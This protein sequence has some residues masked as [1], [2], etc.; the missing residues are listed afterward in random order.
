MAQSECSNSGCENKV[1]SA[2]SCSICDAF[3]CLDCMTESA[4]SI[5]LDCGA[6][7]VQGNSPKFSDWEGGSLRDWFYDGFI[8]TFIQR[9]ERGQVFGIHCPFAD[10]ADGF[11][12]TLP[13]SHSWSE[14]EG[15]IEEAKKSPA[16]SQWLLNYA[17][18][19]YD[20]I[21]N[22][23][24]EEAFEKLKYRIKSED[25][26]WKGLEFEILRFENKNGPLPW[27]DHG[28]VIVTLDMGKNV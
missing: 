17:F 7:E 26:W 2:F 1:T 16:Y 12:I 19:Q 6:R 23:S 21:S 14:L 15:S 9:C 24:I 8:S 20:F 11:T 28:R 4:M 22:S 18:I 25:S 13:S 10:T 3:K 27:Q 5:C